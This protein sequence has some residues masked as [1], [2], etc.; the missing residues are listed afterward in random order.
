M[1]KIPNKLNRVYLRD[2]KPP[3]SE[4]LLS[5]ATYI[6]FELIFV[7]IRI[8]LLKYYRFVVF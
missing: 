1:R 5:R 8:W 6:H 4:F 3:K 7:I 2:Q